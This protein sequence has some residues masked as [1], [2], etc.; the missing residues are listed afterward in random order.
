MSPY[1]NHVYGWAPEVDTED[2]SSDS[3]HVLLTHSRYTHSSSSC[4]PISSPEPGSSPYSPDE[5]NES[6]TARKGDPEWVP[7]PRNAFI[8]YRCEYTREHSRGGPR[9]RNQPH[10]DKT[11]SKRAAEAWHDLPAEQ[12]KKFKMLA[13][14]EKLEHAKAY[15]NYRFKPARKTGGS[16]GR[17]RKVR[18]SAPVPVR[19]DR[20]TGSVEPSEHES[21]DSLSPPLERLTLDSSY[22]PYVMPPIQG[23]D[24]ALS[25]TDSGLRRSESSTETW[26]QSSTCSEGSTL[27][28]DGTYEYV[29]SPSADIPSSV[30][31]DCHTNYIHTPTPS[32]YQSPTSVISSSLANWNGDPSLPS[33]P[34][35]STAHWSTGAFQY[36]INNRT[37]TI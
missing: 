4:S 11:L 22:R 31:T 19:R 2:T 25:L 23:S 33:T 9:G 35:S 10:T 5:A 16:A 3:C 27:V 15:P 37:T 32:Y 36:P 6:R 14:Q 20:H 8:I 18:S 1:R 21:L 13:E 17:R 12:K 28:C 29:S 26:T 34:S 24:A 7:R 30:K